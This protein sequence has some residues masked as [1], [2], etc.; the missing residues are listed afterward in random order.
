[1][2]RT[3]HP[4]IRDISLPMRVLCP[5]S[6]LGGRAFYMRYDTCVGLPS[7]LGRQAVATKHE[8][9]YTAACSGPRRRLR[10][11]ADWSFV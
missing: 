3:W 2:G 4:R 6:L 7:A 9:R 5:A 1:M 8:E 11:S 10:S